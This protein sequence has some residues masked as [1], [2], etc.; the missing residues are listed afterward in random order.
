[1]VLDDAAFLHAVRLPDEMHGD[2]H[3]DLLV[4]AHH[5]EIDVQE[6][7]ADVVALDL[8]GHREVLVLAYLEIDQHVRAGA[9][10]QHVVELAPVDGELQGLHPVPVQDPGDEPAR[11]ELPRGSLAPAVTQSSRQLGL[12]HGRS[13]Y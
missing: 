7:P 2:V 11:A 5:E 9:R 13:L 3:R 6:L 1:M 12:G 8:T 4:A 10:V